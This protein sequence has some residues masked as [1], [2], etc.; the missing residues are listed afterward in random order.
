MM[1]LIYVLR[2]H[3]NREAIERW[4]HSGSTI[5]SIIGEAASC[6]FRCRARI[7]PPPRDDA[8]IPVQI[9]NHQRFSPFFDDCIAALEG[10][11]VG[12]LH[13]SEIEE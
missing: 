8:N 4:Q 5:S 13:N 2:G 1:I 9:A 6:F 11:Q 7:Y 10:T 12:N 3:T